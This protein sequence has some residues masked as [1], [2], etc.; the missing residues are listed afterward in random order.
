MTTFRNSI[1]IGSAF[2]I[3]ISIGYAQEQ[4][5]PIPAGTEYF[6]ESWTGQ[7]G[8][9]DQTDHKP[10]G[11]GNQMACVDVS[12]KDGSVTGCHL[13]FENGNHYDLTYRQATQAPDTDVVY[14]TC[15]TKDN[16]DVKTKSCKLSVI[17]PK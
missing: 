1:L 9:P 3:S 16:T 13:K 17:P 12:P 14:L 10:V 7:T 5:P 15:T 6:L 2:A 11:K 4:H 8:K